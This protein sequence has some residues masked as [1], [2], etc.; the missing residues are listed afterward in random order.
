MADPFVFENVNLRSLRVFLVEINDGQ[1][2]VDRLA[3][4]ENVSAD[5]RCV[6]DFVYGQFRQSQAD[7]STA[8]FD[9]HF[10]A[11]H[12]FVFDGACRDTQS[13]RFTDAFVL[14]RV[15]GIGVLQHIE[16]DRPGGVIHTVLLELLPFGALVEREAL[17]QLLNVA[18][19]LLFHLLV[20]EASPSRVFVGQ[21]RNTAGQ[22]QFG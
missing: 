5:A 10:G 19:I 18:H 15:A 8:F 11:V 14:D 9:Q 16:D 2:Y 17:S 7:I 6:E 12:G 4:Q 3:D 1:R 21:F 13:F 20:V 22:L